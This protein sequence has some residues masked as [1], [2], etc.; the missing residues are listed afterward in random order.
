MWLEEPGS[1]HRSLSLEDEGRQSTPK[2]IERV[3]KKDMFPV[4]RHLTIY[5]V[6]QISQ[7]NFRFWPDV[8]I[9]EWPFSTAAF[10][11]PILIVG[12]RQ[13]AVRETLGNS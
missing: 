4:L 5:D 7:A 1:P 9:L 11:E 8:V 10:R 3:F 13:V 6:I 2:Q 12:N